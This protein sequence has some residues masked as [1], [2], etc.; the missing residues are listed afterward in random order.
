[1]GLARIW[2]PPPRR[3]GTSGKLLMTLLI[4]LICEMGTMS[5]LDYLVKSDNIHKGLRAAA[6]TMETIEN[7]LA[8]IT[9]T[10]VVWGGYE[11]QHRIKCVPGKSLT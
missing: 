10:I 5:I 11:S 3:H 7:L 8:I 4:H 9:T 1:M 2:A 6:E